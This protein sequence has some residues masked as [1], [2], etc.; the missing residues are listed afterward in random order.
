MAV[1]ILHFSTPLKHAQHYTG[2]AKDVDER[3]KEHCNGTG[4]RITQV[5]N[6]QGITY[7]I[8]RVFKGKDRKFERRLKNTHKVKVYCSICM[9]NKCRKYKP[10]VAPTDK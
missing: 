4:A 2:Y 7:Q 5:C 6:E 10:E 1:Y 3:F 8:A 9:G